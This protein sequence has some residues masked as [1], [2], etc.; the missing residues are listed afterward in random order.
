MAK[1]VTNLPSGSVSGSVITMVADPVT[2][3]MFEV[4]F[5]Q[6]KDYVGGGS[7]GLKLDNN[8]LVL[9]NS[10]ASLNLSA[11][12]TW[13]GNINLLS[14]SSFVYGLGATASA[15]PID[16]YQYVGVTNADVMLARFQGRN[17]LSGGARNTFIKF[18]GDSATTSWFDFVNDGGGQFYFKYGN[19]ATAIGTT[20]PVSFVQ[21]G[22]FS[23]ATSLSIGFGGGAYAPSSTFLQLPASTTAKSSLNFTS[24]SIPTAPVNGDVF[25]DSSGSMQYHINGLNKFMLMGISGSAPSNTTTPAL[26]LT[27]TISGSTYKTPLYQ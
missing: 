16:V 13:G 12:N 27:V 26:W 8:T 2:G 19:S 11:S 25:T 9:V 20:I 21:D 23:I 22:R 3:Q 10:S 7:S 14:G 24:G 18:G 5:Q 6:V 1:F 4:N 15:A 17:N